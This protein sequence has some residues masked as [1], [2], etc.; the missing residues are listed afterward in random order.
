MLKRWTVFALGLLGILLA[1]TGCSDDENAGAKKVGWAI[2][3]RSDYTAAIL[4]TNNGGR[5]WEEQGNPALWT[6]MGG[7]DIS[8]VDDLTAWAAVGRR[9]CGR[10]DSAH[11]KRRRRL[12]SADFAR[13][14]Q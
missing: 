9:E 11:C 6:G 8:A 3:W 4:H 7:N 2:G 13:G 10:R 12:E 5:T 1:M 14:R